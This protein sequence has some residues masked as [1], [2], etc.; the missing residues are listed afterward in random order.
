MIAIPGTT[1]ASRIE[2]NW[3]SRDVDLTEEEKQEL[4]RIVD[5]AKP[6]GNRYSERAQSMVGH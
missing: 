2:E 3:A 4:R 5:S 6:V 1:K